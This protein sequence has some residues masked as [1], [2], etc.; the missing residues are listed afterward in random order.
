MIAAALVPLLALVGGAIDMG[1]SYLSQTRL[2]QACDAGV[3]AARKKLGPNLLT[4]TTLPADVINIGNRFFGFNFPIGSYGTANRSFQ[5]EVSSNH[6]ITG[7]AK[8][9]VPTT[10][11]GIF[12]YTKIDVETK[13]SSSMSIGNTDIMLVIDTSGSM[14]QTN[15]GD[16]QPRFTILRDVLNRFNG[17]V[18]TLQ[19]SG[20]RLRFGFVPYTANVNVGGLLKPEWMVDRWNYQGRVLHDTSTMTTGTLIDQQWT[21]ISGSE[22]ISEPFLVTS[23]PANTVTATKV[24]SWTDPAGIVH[25]DYVMNGNR[26]KCN[27]S[28]ASY[29]RMIKIS[30]TDF[31]YRLSTKTLSNQTFPVKTWRY[32]RLNNIDVSPLKDF[33]TGKMRVGAPLRFPLMGGT[34]DAPTMFTAYF[35]GCIE[36]RDSYEIG[37][38]GTLD[39]TRALDLDIDLIPDPGNPATQWRPVLHEVAFLR[40]MYLNRSG[41]VTVAPRDYSG[42][43][44]QAYTNCPTAARK[45]APMSTAEFASYVDGLAPFMGTNHDIGMI[46]G[47]RLLSPTGLFAEENADVAGSPTARHLIFLTDGLT[48]GSPDDYGTYGIEWL[49]ERRWTRNSPQT[50][51][52]VIEQRFLLA[53]DEAKKRNISVWFVGF[54]V[55]MNPIFTKCAGPGQAFAAMNATELENAFVQIATRI[56]DLRLVK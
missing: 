31:K 51:K 26:Y 12:G 17:R 28:Y 20:N 8:V 36:E 56:G 13:C 5:M 6:T 4:G 53:C 1:R 43:Y 52:Q 29:I 30:Y 39:L 11:M 18:N 40:G 24:A 2:Q 23:C 19:G 3:L 10:I 27:G 21:Y 44:F 15:S 45:L 50:L 7:S 35:Q 47:T 9:D 38:N 14:A 25:D 46:W 16:T 22:K 33:A 32:Q 48:G 49:D 54:G 34:P 55:S 41:T 37:A 42:D